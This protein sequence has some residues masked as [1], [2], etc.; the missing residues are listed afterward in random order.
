MSKIFDHK[1]KI[2]DDEKIE[3]IFYRCVYE[4]IFSKWQRRFISII[5]FVVT[6]GRYF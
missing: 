4:K 1:N 6:K 5:L 2:T 3:A